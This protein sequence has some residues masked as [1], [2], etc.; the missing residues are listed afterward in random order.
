VRGT[1]LPDLSK[2]FGLS[3]NQNGAIAPVQAIGLLIGSVEIG[4]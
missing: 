1:I 3:P 2:R 4:S